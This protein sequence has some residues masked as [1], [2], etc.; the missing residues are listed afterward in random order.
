MV[1]LAG[2]LAEVLTGKQFET[3]I[4]ER[5]FTPLGMTSSTFTADADTAPNLAKSYAEGDGGDMVEVDT[6]LL[7]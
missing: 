1:G 6:V 7:Q 2:H 5:I 4:R 3:L